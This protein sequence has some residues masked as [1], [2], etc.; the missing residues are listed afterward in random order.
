MP[1]EFE[2]P[3]AAMEPSPSIAS[4][5]PDGTEIPAAFS[6]PANELLPTRVSE[7]TALVS[8]ANGLV[9]SAV[10]DSTTLEIETFE[11]PRTAMRTAPA[12]T[13]P[14]DSTANV[15]LSRVNTPSSSKNHPAEMRWPISVPFT[16]KPNGGSFFAA[17]VSA[18][19]T[20]AANSVP[21]TVKPYMPSGSQRRS[22]PSASV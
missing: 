20:R 16:R 4:D 10:A 18:P 12:A 6:P 7:T 21:S 14:S 13:V 22:L 8:S 2:P 15:E 3:V 1:T 11:V 5:A 9:P 19:A 17:V